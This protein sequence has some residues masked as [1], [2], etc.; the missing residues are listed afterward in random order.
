MAKKV[1]K[2]EIDRKT[3]MGC[4]TCTVLA[5]KAF[6]LGEDNLSK[7]KPTW[8]EEEDETLISTTG[9]CPTASITVSDE[10]G[11]SNDKIVL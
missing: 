7:V 3:C 4:G 9:A 6:E 11:N 8:V 2:V 1:V 5:P 10:Q